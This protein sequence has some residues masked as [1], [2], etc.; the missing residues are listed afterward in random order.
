M[1]GSYGVGGINISAKKNSS[2]E[3]L[4]GISIQMR[5]YIFDTGLYSISFHSNKEGAAFYYYNLLDTYDSNQYNVDTVHSGSLHLLRL[6][7][8]NHVVSGTF[9]FDAYNKYLNKTVKITD[10]RFDYHYA[11]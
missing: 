3:P 8:I 9:Y 1:N 5:N 6:D 2:S 4:S 11:N 7:S 10:G